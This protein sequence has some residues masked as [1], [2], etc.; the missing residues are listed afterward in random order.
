MATR[1]N[2]Q[3]RGRSSYRGQSRTRGT[4]SNAVRQGPY[5]DRTNGITKRHAAEIAQRFPAWLVNALDCVQQI[6]LHQGMELH[7]IPPEMQA[8]ITTTIT[9]NA[10]HCTT[11]PSADNQ[12]QQNI[13]ERNTMRKIVNQAIP[14]TSH[15]TGISERRP[16]HMKNSQ[17]TLALGGIA[18]P[19][20]PQSVKN[21]HFEC[22]K[23]EAT[24]AKQRSI[25]SIE[26]LITSEASKHIPTHQAH[27]EKTHT[28]TRENNNG[29]N[30]NAPIIPS[31]TNSE[32]QRYVWQG[33]KE[34]T[35]ERVGSISEEEEEE[36]ILEYS[37]D[38]DENSMGQ[39]G[40]KL[41][42]STAN[43]RPKPIT[44]FTGSLS[45]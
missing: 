15:Q 42:D 12:A 23:H 8:A 34:R 35:D 5:S 45:Q 41:Q 9:A 13:S 44:R 20:Q 37:D 2:R 29:V 14:T 17:K 16:T 40:Y 11:T 1:G 38:E 3:H 7:N 10:H 24:T 21:N 43:K 18:A 32:Q 4:V 25:H 22:D 28:V 19:S 39:G 31:N 27:R 30:L 36:C 6:A 26:M 33:V